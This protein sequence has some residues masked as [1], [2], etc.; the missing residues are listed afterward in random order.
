MNYLAVD[1]SSSHLGVL[2]KKDGNFYKFYKPDAQLTHSVELMPAVDGLLKANGI[3]LEE[4]DAFGAVVGAG[5]FTGIRIGIAA[6]KGFCDC[7]KK[8]AFTVTAFETL[9]YN[10]K[11]E[12]KILAVLDAR[13]NHYYAAGFSGGEQVLEPCF[14]S[15]DQLKE[16]SR[17]YVLASS[18][19]L[20][21]FD[22]EIADLQE[23]FVS[24]CEKNCR[25]TIASDE[26]A[27]L[28][29]RKSQAEEHR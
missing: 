26:I 27:P 25:N 16:L 3:S 20:N 22:V 11:T 24:A 28:Y 10:I 29:I 9:A 15:S 19:A 1:T 7:L 23:G 12:N 18:C 17:E 8:P 21:G 5:S 14:I 2:I 4:M 6:V 13:H